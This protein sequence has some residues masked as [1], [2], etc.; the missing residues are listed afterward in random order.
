[1]YLAL[2]W[3]LVLVFP[4]QKWPLLLAFV[5]PSAQGSVAKPATVSVP[6]CKGLQNPLSAHELAI[7]VK[8]IIPFRL[9]QGGLA[10]VRRSSL[11]STTPAFPI[12][13]Q[14]PLVRRELIQHP[15]ACCAFRREFLPHGSVGAA[16]ADISLFMK[17]KIGNGSG[18]VPVRVENSQL[19]RHKKHFNYTLLQLSKV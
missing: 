3:E 14:H 12:N 15:A 19:T 7:I 4:V 17:M 2:H 5:W 9:Y 13:Q 18:Y 16:A 11:R 10:T 8:K 6:Q 1:M